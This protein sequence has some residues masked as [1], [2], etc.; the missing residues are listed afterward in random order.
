MEN[1]KECWFLKTRALHSFEGQECLHY[2][3]DGRGRVDSVT[4][5]NITEGL[6]SK[7]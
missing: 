6:S 5:K 1:Q 3:V 2:R 7:L 4:C